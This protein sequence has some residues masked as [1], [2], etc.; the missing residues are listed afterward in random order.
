MFGEVEVLLPSGGDDHPLP[1][2]RVGTGHAAHHLHQSEESIV[3]M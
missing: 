2:L 3:V 1:Q